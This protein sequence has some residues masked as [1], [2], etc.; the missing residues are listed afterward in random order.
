MGGFQLFPLECPVDVN[1]STG[2]AVVEGEYDS[3]AL[4]AAVR[5]AGFDVV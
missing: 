2:K 4:V 5:N 1:L 3:D